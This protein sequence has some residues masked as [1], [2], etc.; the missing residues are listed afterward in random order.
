MTRRWQLAA[1][2]VA[3]DDATSPWLT[4][5]EGLHAAVRR[6]LGDSE[7]RAYEGVN[8]GGAN[9]VYW[10]ELI[11]RCDDGL[12]RVR[13]LTAGAKRKIRQV[14]SLLESDR[15]YPLLR[16]R[17]VRRWQAH[18][19][20]YILLVQ[21]VDRRCGIDAATLQLECPRTWEYLQQFEQPLRVF[22][23]M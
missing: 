17:E 20:A 6:L 19:S 23:T 13:N 14:E 9:G 1:E 21:N 22:K 3:A 2:P 5:R 10:L 15:V 11:E 12:L 4:V 18:A 7:Y 16:G 8:T